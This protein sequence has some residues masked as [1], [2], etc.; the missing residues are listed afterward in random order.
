MRIKTITIILFYFIAVIC[1]AQET[2]LKLSKSG[3]LREGNTVLA[4]GMEEDK[5]TAILFDDQLKELKK[6]TKEV[7][8]KGIMLKRSGN[9]FLF[10]IYEK[11]F[12]GKGT[13]ILLS[14]V[15]EELGAKQFSGSDEYSSASN[16]LYGKGSEDKNSKLF[17]EINSNGNIFESNIYSNKRGIV[18]ISVVS[19]RGQA[20]SL[21]PSDWNNRESSLIAI[22][23][24][25]GKK[26]F[27]TVLQ[28]NN[29]DHRPFVSAMYYDPA[30]NSIVI[31]G[32]YFD[33]NEVKNIKENQQWEEM[34]GFFMI[35]MDMK[36]KIL[37]SFEEKFNDP[38]PSDIKE[39]IYRNKLFAV[40]AIQKTSS[41]K[42]K[43]FGEQMLKYVRSYYNTTQAGQMLVSNTVYH[44]YGFALYEFSSSLVKEKR[45]ILAEKIVLDQSGK[46]RD[47]DFNKSIHNK[48]Y[49]L[50]M[51]SVLANSDPEVR[52]V[53]CYDKW[54]DNIVYK[55][56]GC[57]MTMTK[58]SSDNPIYTNL[59]DV[60]IEEGMTFESTP[61]ILGQ[62]LEN[63]FIV[64]IPKKS[65]I[66]L[67]RMKY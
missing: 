48:E 30:D 47:F 56:G 13:L 15:L 67:R 60:Y 46:L 51:I 54:F 41:G 23:S 21:L 24:T 31:A 12:A 19:F 9:N 29:K 64:V 32:D 10:E 3:V 37:N 65:K 20:S 36:G 4:Y 33:L 14:P 43:V 45:S 66:I 57:Y 55:V 5:F 42:Y 52:I 11:I 63:E 17:E 50:S 49:P 35:K 1:E 34:H 2:V 53:K 6:Y 27:D 8:C 58:L 28:L 62:G 40:T 7:K 38:K 44:T 25:S 22:D 26:I 59:K 16:E 61:L 18:F 39:N